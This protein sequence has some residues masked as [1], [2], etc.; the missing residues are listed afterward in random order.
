MIFIDSSTSSKLSSFVDREILAEV[1][2][3]FIVT[4]SDKALKSVPEI[5]VPELEAHRS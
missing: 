3:G 5:A 4:D 2:P 1:L